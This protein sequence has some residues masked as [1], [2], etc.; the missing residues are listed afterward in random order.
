[1]V[2]DQS[3]EVNILQ[4]EPADLITQERT[5]MKSSHLVYGFSMTRITRSTIFRGRDQR[6]KVKVTRLHELKQTMHP[7][8]TD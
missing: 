6:S 2:S 8:I 1:M 5:V 7:S 3:Y 4:C